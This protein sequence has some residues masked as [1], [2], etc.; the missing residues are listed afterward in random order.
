LAKHTISLELPQAE[1]VN[2]D[3]VV[4]IR[5]DGG[6]LG[7]I[8]V[9]R[10]NI[11]WYSCHWKQPTKLTWEEFDRVMHENWKPARKRK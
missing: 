10:G 8:T 1:V 3:A 2:S 4:T 7:R 6:V 9:S 5:A 11:E